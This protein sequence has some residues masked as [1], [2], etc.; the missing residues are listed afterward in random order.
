MIIYKLC[1]FLDLPASM[2]P[3]IAIKF[4]LVIH[5]S[6]VAP[7]SG[8]PLTT[9]AVTSRVAVNAN[10][11]AFCAANDDVKLPSLVGNC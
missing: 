10:M 2:V 7:C 4:I 5:V 3:R 11:S 8:K 6:G 9:N 1:S